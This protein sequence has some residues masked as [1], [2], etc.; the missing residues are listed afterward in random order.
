MSG[1]ETPA[2]LGPT[3]L[4]I[5][6]VP[7][8]DPFDHRRETGSVT[9]GEQVLSELNRLGVELSVDG[10]QIRYRAPTGIVT[11]E[12]LN[13]LKTHKA[14]VLEAL[15]RGNG[16]GEHDVEVARRIEAFRALLQEGQKSGRARIPVLVLPGAGRS[17]AEGCIS[18]GRLIA[19]DRLRCEPCREA[20][21]RVVAEAQSTQATD[22]RVGPSGELAVPFAADARFHWWEGKTPEERAERFRAARI[23]AGLP[24]DDSGPDS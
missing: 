23:A 2:P 24:L 8:S 1:A 18:C 21:L 9:K 5:S 7:S 13:L 6:A 11:P 19:K 12:I 4:R 14:E 17:K 15:K 16:A 20:A 10:D 3:G 22:P